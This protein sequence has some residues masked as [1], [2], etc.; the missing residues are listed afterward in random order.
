MAGNVV[1]AKLALVVD[2]FNKNARDAANAVRDLTRQMKGDFSQQGQSVKEAAN[3]HDSLLAKFKEFRGEQVQQ[4]RMA[5][6]YAGELAS[7]IPAGDGVKQTMQGLLGVIIEGAAGGASFGL[8]FEAAKFALEV[9]IKSEEEAK[10][11]AQ[12]HRDAVVALT[13][14]FDKYS[15]SALNASATEKTFQDA[16]KKDRAALSDKQ[17][18]LADLK[19]QIT[20]LAA[21]DSEGM[22]GVQIERLQKQAEE[23]DREISQIQNRIDIARAMKEEADKNV[24]ASKAPEAVNKS[25]TQD[26][27]KAKERS[28]L[29]L[30]NYA[31]Q[32][33]VE[34]ELDQEASRRADANLAADTK[35]REELADLELKNYARSLQ[36]EAD[37]DEQASRKADANL[38][39]DNARRERMMQVSAMQ[40]AMTAEQLGSAFG[41]A[42]GAMIEGTK[43][44]GQAFAQMAQQMIQ[45]IAQIAIKSI[46][47]SAGK[48]AAE[49]ISS[50]AG[51]PVIGPILAIS[52]GAAMF[53]AAIG[54]LGKI[55]SA[56]GGWDLPGGGPFPAVLHANEMVLPSKYADVI[57]GMA[58]GG[59]GGGGGNVYIGS[60]QAWD[61]PSVERT[62]IAYK[63][64]LQRNGRWG[65]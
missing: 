53:S 52:A 60:I 31:R 33:Q 46:T 65:T 7:I 48:A 27:E 54:Y 23:L 41:N 22:R 58:D 56:E 29:E 37:M 25:T 64:K 14:A 10:K 24:A 15:L 61:G 34:E 26:A 32:L 3:E 5:R 1:E 21:G 12:E 30:Q 2:E 13:D 9:F 49:G 8:A 28:E 50:Q 51:I 44:V 63:R 59:G 18:A 4:G 45:T 57:R 38:A 42:F 62:L 16:T 20:D 6:F 17:K 36:V 40:M 47:A 55:G 11:K 39:A 35:K 19:Q 43:S